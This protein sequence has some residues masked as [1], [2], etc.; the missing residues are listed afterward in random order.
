MR[1]KITV[2]AGNYYSPCNKIPSAVGRKENPLR[3]LEIG[4]YRHNMQLD[5]E[6]YLRRLP[7][8]H[9]EF[10]LLPLVF[11]RIKEPEI[12]EIIGYHTSIMGG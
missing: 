6:S 12:I 4:Q 9:L 8:I 7:F 5:S 1:R 2:W 3:G 10:D 11:L